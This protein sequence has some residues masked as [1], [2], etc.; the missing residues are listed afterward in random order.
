MHAL[1]QHSRLAALYLRGGRIAVWASMFLAVPLIV[2]AYDLFALFLGNKY[3]DHTD[4]A[5][6]MILLRRP[7]SL[8]SISRSAP[9]PG[10]RSQ[11]TDH[12]RFR[13]AY[14][15]TLIGLR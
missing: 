7:G 9:P 5:T 11:R 8:L 3:L 2:F 10:R 15:R 1:D 12:R 14:R 6:V 13:L 4:A